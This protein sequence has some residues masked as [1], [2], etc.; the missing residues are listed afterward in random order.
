MVNLRKG[1]HVAIAPRSAHLVVKIFHQADLEVLA[2][3]S[4]AVN[5]LI[6]TLAFWHLMT[7]DF[8][9]C[10]LAIYLL[11]LL[12]FS[13]GIS[14]SMPIYVH[15]IHLYLFYLHERIVMDRAINS[16]NPQK[17]L[18][19]TDQL[20]WSNLPSTNNH[21][22]VQATNT[23]STHRPTCS[24]LHAVTQKHEWHLEIT[25]WFTVNNFFYGV[26]WVLVQG[27][28][29]RFTTAKVLVQ[30]DSNLSGLLSLR[31]S[32]GRSK[33]PSPHINATTQLR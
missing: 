23:Q 9:I 5:S 6:V 33:S 18:E 24:K 17:F 10:W 4:A 27:Q 22:A 12:I 2:V 7:S 28:P 20:P 8:V 13:Y 11:Y 30:K 25:H 32:G 1:F 29:A 26:L 21:L 14:K 15:I 3:A 31:S 19:S 16:I